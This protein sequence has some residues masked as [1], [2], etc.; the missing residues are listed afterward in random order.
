MSREDEFTDEPRRRRDD[1]YSDEPRRRDRDDED[2]DYDRPRRRSRDDDDY[3][4]VRRRPPSG[5]DNFFSNNLA[6]A[7]I[8]L[9]C[10]TPVALILGIIGLATCKEEDARR[11]ALVITIISGIFVGIGVVLNIIEA[12]NK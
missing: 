6:L 4:D 9:L 1:E 3:L 2:D 10:C 5:M 12:I 8:L 7:I 11:R